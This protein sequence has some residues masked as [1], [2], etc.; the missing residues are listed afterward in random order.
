MGTDIRRIFGGVLKLRLI[1]ALKIVWIILSLMLISGVTDKTSGAVIV[2]IVVNL[3][4]ALLSLTTIN[5]EIEE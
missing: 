2:I 4:C 5:V 3:C 1:D